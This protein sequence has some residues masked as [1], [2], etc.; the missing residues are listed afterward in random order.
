M[1]T[2]EELIRREI[3]KIRRRGSILPPQIDLPQQ[4][5]TPQ[6]VPI[7][8][9]QQP[10]VQSAPVG[11]GVSSGL[12]GAGQMAGDGQTG[13]ALKGAGTGAAVGTAVMPGIGTAVGA[14]VGLIA[15]L[16]SGA[17]KSRAQKRK[18]AVERQQKGIDIQSRGFQQLSAGQAKAFDSLISGFRSALIG[19][20]G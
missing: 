1:A 12:S 9:T 10:G 11:S 20:G 16:A 8:Q 18:E 13:E 4:Q 6:Q 14:G 19:T 7:P 5:A 15:G 2:N 17:A 3:E